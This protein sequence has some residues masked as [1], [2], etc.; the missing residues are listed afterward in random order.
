MYSF[1]QWET[2]FIQFFICSTLH[3]SS[4]SSPSLMI[5]YFYNRISTSEKGIQFKYLRMRLIW[6]VEKE[7]RSIPQ[8]TARWASRFFSFRLFFASESDSSLLLSRKSD[9]TAAFGRLRAGERKWRYRREDGTAEDGRR[10]V[11]VSAA[12]RSEFERRRSWRVEREQEWRCH[13]GQCIRGRITWAIRSWKLTVHFS[14]CT[15]LFFSLLTSS[16]GRQGLA[17]P[18]PGGLFLVQGCMAQTQL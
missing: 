3:L 1:V 8:R 14:I 10:R 7:A 15:V 4:S 18:H 16:C 6:G 2:V 9:G 13:R 5:P 12:A 11:A 17:S